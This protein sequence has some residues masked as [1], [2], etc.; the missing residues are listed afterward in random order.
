MTKPQVTQFKD[1][2]RGVPTVAQQKQT[3]PVS[4]RMRVWSLALLSAL[5]IWCCCELWYRHGSGTAVAVA[6]VAAVALIWPLAL[7]FPYAT[8]VAPKT[9]KQK[10]QRGVPTV[11]QWVADP[12]CL[13]GGASSILVPRQWVED[14]VCCS[15]GIGHSSRTSCVAGAAKRGKKKKKKK[16]GKEPECSLLQTYK[17]SVVIWKGAQHR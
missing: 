6:V 3:R 9:N 2:Q 1:G 11:V 15:C 10:G 7:E 17:W 5:R 14:P 4:M 13:C 8:P 12:A 16:K